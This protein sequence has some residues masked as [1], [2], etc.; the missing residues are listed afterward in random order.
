ARR[1]VKS[2]RE[3][4]D[5]FVDR[6][7]TAGGSLVLHR[8]VIGW[9]LLRAPA[10]LFL[11]APALAVMLSGRAARRLGHRRLAEWLGARR[12]LLDTALSREIEW[13]V[14]TELLELPCVQRGRM[15]TRDAL[16]ETILGDPR[17]ARRLAVPFSGPDSPGAAELRQRLYGAIASY[18]GTR[19]AV[20]EIATGIAAAGVGVL[21]VKQAT[22]GLI[23]LGSALAT[24]I[25]QQSAI[26]AFPLGAWLG[27]IWYG[28]YPVAAGPGL[29]AVTIGGALAA[30]TLLSAF[31]GIATD[32]LQ[33][34]LGVHRR[35]LQRLLDALESALC[36]ERA[37]P[38]ALR[39]HYVAR[40]LDL[41]DYAAMLWRLTH[42]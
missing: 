29:T 10:N 35:R 13:L 21:V 18:A 41:L 6:H 20:A 17:A 11:S 40:L 2:R 26:A 23:T 24:A 25:A 12:I 27:S 28:W 42:A 34:R 3:R 7:F 30:G 4:V 31:S 16:A 1:Y 5:G 22:P 19:A 33:R 36:D 32:P 39:D 15:T 9:D 14:T 8:R 38:L 37:E